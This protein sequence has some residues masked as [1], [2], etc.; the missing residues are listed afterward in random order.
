MISALHYYGYFGNASNIKNNKILQL[1][2]RNAIENNK[3][4]SV[5]LETAY[6]KDVISYA[7]DLS[8]SVN[9]M[10]TISYALLND[11]S[12]YVSDEINDGKS[13]RNGTKSDKYEKNS[14]DNKKEKSLFNLSLSEYFG[15]SLEKFTKALN[16][17]VAF[18]KMSSQ[19]RNFDDF[20]ENIA[21]IVNNSPSLNKLGISF[22]ESSYY[23]DEN[24]I[25]N[26]DVEDAMNLLKQSYDSIVAVYNKTSDF[27]STPLTDHMAFKNFSYYYSYSTGVMQNNLFSL[28][29]AGTLVDLKL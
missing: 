12:E 7:K 11:I 5:K 9:E 29:G 15:N 22:K 13:K 18:K 27:L 24:A 4:K 14:N 25:N 2:Y 26:L 16:K 3:S 17:T 21:E 20:A 6:K 8:Q 10:K 28:F 23:V 19:S 1:P